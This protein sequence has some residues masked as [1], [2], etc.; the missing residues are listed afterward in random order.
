[1]T[2]SLLTRVLPNQLAN[3]RVPDLEDGR[4]RYVQSNIMAIAISIIST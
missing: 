1:M 2:S 4:D 3:A